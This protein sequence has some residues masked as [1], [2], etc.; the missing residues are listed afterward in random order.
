MEILGARVNWHIGF[1]ND[2]T[3]EVW[4]GSL[5]SIEDLVYK[6]I[7]T[8]PDTSFYHAE[9]D[10]YVHYL[11]HDPR[12]TRGFGGRAF[13]LN[14]EDETEKVIKG[15]WSSRAAVYNDL[16]PGPD[17]VD[18]SITDEAEVFERGH[19]FRAGSILLG[20]ATEAA[21]LAGVIL[22][23]SPY[24]RREHERIWI[25]RRA[26][27]D[28]RGTL[29]LKLPEDVN[30]ILQLCKGYLKGDDLAKYVIGKNEEP[31][32]RDIFN[33]WYRGVKYLRKFYGRGWQTLLK[34]KLDGPDYVER[35]VIE[36]TESLLER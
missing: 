34:E 13:T 36:K 12:D 28:F 9:K 24:L 23:E 18:V 31:R 3:L 11:Y 25:P 21:E 7:K 27:H 2:P 33:S 20:K 32:V 14:M 16:V 15:P 17:C 29:Y 22:E 4:V 19:T 35:H 5:P 6:E 30:V 8:G 1:D 26:S 10:G